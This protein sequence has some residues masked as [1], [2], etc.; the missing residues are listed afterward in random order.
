MLAAVLS[1]GLLAAAPAFAQPGVPSLRAPI[2][3]TGPAAIPARIDVRRG[4]SLEVS[5]NN[6]RLEK[7]VYDEDCQKG[8][9]QFHCYYNVRITNTGPGPYSGPVTVRDVV[10]AGT[11]ALFGGGWNCH[12]AHPQYTCSRKVNLPNPGDDIILAVQIT[13]PNGVAPSLACRVSSEARIVFAPGGSPNNITAADDK[14]DAVAKL[15]A[16]L[17]DRVLVKARPDCPPGFRREAD[18]DGCVRA[19]RL[20]PVPQD[21]CRRGYWRT[22]GH[23]CPLGQAWNGKRCAPEER[24]QG[25]PPCRAGT[26]GVYPNCVVETGAAANC[27]PSTRYDGKRCVKAEEPDDARCGRGEYLSEG[28]CCARGTVWNGK[29]CL[30]SP[31]LQPSCP[32][33]TVGT[34]PDCRG[35]REQ[36]CPSGTTGR[37]PNCTPLRACPPGTV[38]AYPNC[39]AAQAERCPPGTRGAYPNCIPTARLC[40]PGTTG[41][42]PI[43]RPSGGRTCPPGTVGSGN[44]CLQLQPQHPVPQLRRPTGSDL[45]GPRAPQFGPSPRPPV[46]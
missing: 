7:R 12:D 5:R 17:C 41:I 20:L 37:F 34:F 32:R 23:C 36:V 27:P 16:E 18:G 40:P 4:G 35:A 13:V 33:G 11:S 3:A 29:R 39:R 10:P 24:S 2:T 45:A 31:G 28:H 21:G 38:G 9:G 25:K 19:V 42:P 30:R 26:T 43:C 15:P 46:R 6:L 8:E 1:S 14:G 22:E 44:R